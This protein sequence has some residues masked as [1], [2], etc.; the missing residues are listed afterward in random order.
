MTTWTVIDQTKPDRLTV[1]YSSD[2]GTQHVTMPDMFWDQVT[3]LET[4][5]GRVNPWPAPPETPLIRT[6]VVGM[7]GTSLPIERTP[8]VSA[9]DLAKLK[10]P[11]DP[12]TA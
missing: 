1:R 7:T 11:A 2:D 9:E 12:L 4:W 5:L 6:S 8:P 10:P 3:P